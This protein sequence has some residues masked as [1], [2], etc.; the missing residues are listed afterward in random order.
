MLNKASLN[1]K[2][3]SEK[4]HYREVVFYPKE[5]NYMFQ[6]VMITFSVGVKA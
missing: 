4:S 6:Q 5:V 3:P 1:V 2:D